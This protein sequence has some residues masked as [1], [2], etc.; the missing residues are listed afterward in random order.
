MAQVGVAEPPRWQLDTIYPDIDSAEFV[1]DRE[2]LRDTLKALEDHVGTQRAPAAGEQAAALDRALELYERAASLVVCVANY[3]YLRV[4][5]DSFDA[6]AQAALAA[7]DSDLGRF[8]VFNTRFI[9]WIAR[10]DLEAA[11]RES[12]LV[13]ENGYLLSRY[14][15]ENAHLMPDPAE[16]LAAALES[17]GGAAWARLYGDLIA[18]ER[19]DLP[20]IASDAAGSPPE[21][22]PRTALGTAQL[23]TLQS[24]SDR[25]VRRAAYEAELALLGRNEVSFAAALNGIKGQANALTSRRGWETAY[26][27]SLF[28]YGVSARAIASMQE[29]CVEAFPT[30]RRYLGTKARLLGLER[31]AW[32]DLYA[33]LPQAT[34]IELSWQE[35]TELVRECFASY[36]VDLVEFA[37]RAFE[38]GWIDAQPREGKRGGAFCKDAYPRGES[39]V[40]LNFG[41]TPGDAIALAHELGHA[42]HV[43]RMVRFGRSVLQTVVPM[44]LAETASIFCET[45]VFDRFVRRAEG[46]QRLAFVELDLQNA[47]QLLLDIHSRFLFES[48]VFDR[49]R[50]RALSPE[51]LRRAMTD[52]QAR[53]YGDALEPDLRHPLMWANKPHYYDGDTPYYNYPYTFGWLFSLGLYARYLVEGEAFRSGFDEL[54]ASSG[55]APVAELARRFGIDIEEPSFWRESL[56]ILSGRVASFEDLALAVEATPSTGGG[57]H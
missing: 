53:T 28:Q 16:E 55:M 40:F 25:R 23:R 1:A 38:S 12:A 47:G 36:S 57:E 6:A 46:R 50:E 13:R 27:Y 11:L 42:Y 37:D 30:M 49:R 32:Y 45:L 17:S 21:G 7:L 41:G 48:E 20:D 15:E 24:H 10:L 19:I 31:L 35:A 39:R 33:P 26:A 9:S 18:R 44:T 8:Q 5:A 34:T 29:A 22:L 56:T 43:D 2:R 14:R 52:A 4:A 54:L 51:E 3:L